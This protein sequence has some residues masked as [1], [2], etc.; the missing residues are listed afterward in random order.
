VWP[1][2]LLEAA[3][4]HQQP[5]EDLGSAASTFLETLYT[6]PDWPEVEG[7]LN[8][9]LRDD[10]V[11]DI[12]RQGQST[13][14]MRKM[15]VYLGLTDDGFEETQDWKPDPFQESPDASDLEDIQE[16]L[17]K[18]EAIKKKEREDAQR[19]LAADLEAAEEEFRARV[20]EITAQLPEVAK[21]AE[22]T[23]A[24]SPRA[25]TAARIARQVRLAHLSSL[26]PYWMLIVLYWL[27]VH[28]TVGDM[29]A[30]TLWYMVVSDYFKKQQGS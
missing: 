14:H 15:A 21:A 8:R 30:L 28:L 11:E 13:G 16:I 9:L 5:P 20:A 24:D 27:I 1:K 22:N 25:R 23:P 2:W 26:G 4:Q 29:A 3:A 6:A 12:S 7:E 10:S 17:D 19:S 18:V